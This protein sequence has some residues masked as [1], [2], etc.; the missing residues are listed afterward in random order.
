MRGDVMRII[1]SILLL[2]TALSACQ[3]AK[4]LTEQADALPSLTLA[5]LHRG[6]AEGE[7]TRSCVQESPGK[8][9]CSYKNSASLTSVEVPQEAVP[10]QAQIYLH[11]DFTT[12]ADLIAQG[13]KNRPK[14]SVRHIC[15]GALIAP[16]WIATAA[17]CFPDPELD[18]L[19]GVRLG[20]NNIQAESGYLYHVKEVLRR[21]P[22]GRSRDND[23]ALVRIDPSETDITSV[24]NS[25]LASLAAFPAPIINVVE[26]LA[27]ASFMVLDSLDNLQIFDSATWQPKAKTVFTGGLELFDAEPR[28]LSWS[29]DVIII[30]AMD[31]SSPRQVLDHPNVYHAQLVANETQIIS[32]SHRNGLVRIWDVLTGEIIS[33]FNFDD[34]V[35][36]IIP[37]VDGQNILVR[38][39]FGKLRLY[40]SQTG[41]EYN[42]TLPD[43]YKYLTLVSGGES[44]LLATVGGTGFILLS[45]RDGSRIASKDTPKFNTSSLR[46][47]DDHIIAHAGSDLNV[48]DLETIELVASLPLYHMGT[49]FD[50]QQYENQ[51]HIL[52]S[53]RKMG[54]AEI[55]NLKTGNLV[56]N[57]AAEYGD[58]IYRVELYETQDRAIVH[59]TRPISVVN[60]DLQNIEQIATNP[61]VW[62]L[63]ENRRLAK[64]AKPVG[65]DTL[66]FAKGRW[67]M[68]DGGQKVMYVAYDG[69]TYIWS[70]DTCDDIETDCV[71]TMSMDHSLPIVA[72]NLSEDETSLVVRSVNG[73][74]QVW[75]IESGDVLQQIFHGGRVTGARLRE[76]NK[77]L[78]TYGDNGFLRWWDMTTGKE[79]NRLNFEQA[80][81]VDILAVSAIG[82]DSAPE[83][84]TTLTYIDIDQTGEGIIDGADIRIFGWGRFGRDATAQRSQNLRE[85]GL[86]IISAETCK[87]PDRWGNNPDIHERTFCASDTARKTCVGDSGGPVV[88]GK[89]LAEMK[90]VGIASWG[91]SACEVDGKPGV[92]TR[93][94]SHADWIMKVIGEDA[95]AGDSVF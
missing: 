1:L 56:G 91:S 31:G 28:I 51:E 4:T 81:N 10:F 83:A 33:E 22:D 79:M 18:T 64:L 85:V 67:Q 73:T 62:S 40:N 90:L 69:R 57:I 68:F 29:D 46:Y 5:E 24:S 92:Y 86:K 23:I 61:I 52:I 42:T 39:A 20:L 49:Y 89:N 87:Q 43:R 16:N 76:S 9:F 94:A 21:N 88:Q 82:N 66:K 50:V 71:A 60:G 53:S 65:L 84:E 25:Q 15:G 12:E 36:S 54:S 55:W 32:H 34:E 63:S 3:S 58:K 44:I 59:G 74:V 70:L 75:D 78:M 7:G 45:A 11:P 95:P 41:H 17:H 6:K 38:G 19:Y 8:W 30:T 26:N 47:T 77:R 37:V 2:A 27:N 93:I 13:A 35:H 72:A 48:Y 14:W 80:S